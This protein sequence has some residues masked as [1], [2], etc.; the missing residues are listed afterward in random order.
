MSHEAAK[1]AAFTISFRTL[2][3][4]RPLETPEVGLVIQQGGRMFMFQAKPRVV[5]D[6]DVAPKETVMR[7][8]LLVL[9]IVCV[10]GI[11]S[12]AEAQNYP[13]C[14]YYNFQHGGATNCGWVTFEQCLATVRGIGGSCGPNPMYRARPVQYPLTNHPRRYRY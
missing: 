11:G 1:E 2:L 7:L 8:L 14:A 4:P 12:R 9:G 10:V 13:W 5:N 3:S 6:C